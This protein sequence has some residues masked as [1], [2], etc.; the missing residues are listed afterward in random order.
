VGDLG[1][2]IPFYCE[3]R[4]TWRYRIIRRGIRLEY[5]VGSRARFITANVAYFFW[6][7][8][9]QGEMQARQMFLLAR[10]VKQPWNELSAIVENLQHTST[11]IGQSM[12][13]KHSVTITECDKGEKKWPR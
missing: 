5:R 12:Q 13:Q 4:Q 1:F 2:W 8:S 3:R 10:T 9:K 11:K 7:K 6:M